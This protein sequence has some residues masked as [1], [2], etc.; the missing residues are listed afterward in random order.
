MNMDLEKALYAS[1]VSVAVLGGCKE[2]MVELQNPATR[3]LFEGVYVGQVEG[4][5]AR[6]MVEKE[7]CTFITD[8][9]VSFPYG[10]EMRTIMIRDT[11]CDNSLDSASDKYGVI[12]G[13][14]HF[15]QEGTVDELDSLLEQGQGLVKKENRIRED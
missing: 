2:G 6:Y 12:R 9:K 4:R 10:W 7:T 11:D 13:R 3:P 5:P 14:N 8:Q 1:I 15:I